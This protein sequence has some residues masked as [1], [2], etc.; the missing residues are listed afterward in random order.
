MIFLS[1]ICNNEKHKYL[2]QFVQFVQTAQQSLKSR[3]AIG[4]WKDFIH[5]TK[6]CKLNYQVQTCN[7]LENLVELG[8]TG[9]NF[10]LAIADIPYG[11]EQIG[12]EWNTTDWKALSAK[13]VKVRFINL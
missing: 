10:T 9:A 2:P 6:N 4:I 11:L 1:S 13:I 12:S 3:V 5:P 7:V 8:G